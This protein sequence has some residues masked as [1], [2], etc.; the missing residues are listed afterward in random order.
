MLKQRGRIIQPGSVDLDILAEWEYP[1][2]MRNK[3]G[4][5]WV[6]QWV[7]LNGASPEYR[8]KSGV[9]KTAAKPGSGTDGQVMATRQG[10]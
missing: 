10:V 7:Y 8:V 3:L 9:T 4:T 2:Y 1:L 5:A 6:A